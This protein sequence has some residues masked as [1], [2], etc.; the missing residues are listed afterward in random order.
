MTEKR[1][2]MRQSVL[3]NSFGSYF[4]YFCQWLMTVLVVRISG[5]DDA[6]TLALAI[7][8]CN[9]WQSVALYGMHNYQASDEDDRYSNGVYLASRVVTCAAALVG[10]VVYIILL[11]YTWKQ[12]LTIV[13]FLLLRFSEAVEDVYYAAFQKVWRVDI[14]G[15]SMT[16]RGLLSLIFFVLVLQ[17]SRS[18]ALTI[19][20]CAAA[21]MIVVLLYDRRHAVK[22][23]G[24]RISF[25]R[26]KVL[27]LLKEC[28]PLAIYLLLANFIAMA[29][30]LFMES[31]LGNYKLGIYGSIATPT[32][33][34]QMLS[35]Y[36]FNPFVTLFAEEYHH[37]DK[38]GFIRSFFKCIGILLLISV[39]AVAACAVAGKWALNLLFGSEIAEHSELLIPLVIAS[40]LIAFAT[41]LCSVHT[42]IRSFRIVL[43]SNIIAVILSVVLSLFFEKKFDMQGAN[44]AIIIATLVNILALAGG[45]F[46]K[47]REKFL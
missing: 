16:I 10:C 41:L 14:A 13:L 12:D 29:P 36:A 1:L 25:D 7:S 43:F 6:G 46:S 42:A 22:M 37:K 18:L 47:V 8:A 44:Y 26:E 34:I 31:I 24:I 40:C 21:C 28:L 32:A 35:T 9:V 19:G 23:L 30:R 39:L 2:N 4:Y 33:V 38:K 15:K 5:I 27:S 3:W 45:L 17:S 11:S 20:V